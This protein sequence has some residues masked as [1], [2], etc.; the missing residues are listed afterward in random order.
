MLAATVS[1]VLLAATSTTIDVRDSGHIVRVG[2]FKP[3]QYLGEHSFKGGVV[4]T[5]G[6]AIKAYGRAD[7]KD[8]SGCGNIWRKLGVRLVTA[9]FGGGAPC[10][11]STP[12][13]RIEITA[14]KWQ[15]E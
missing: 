3:K 4:P 13:Q 14:S 2:D 11:S 15:T 5:R 10:V 6:N 12:V 8:S 7:K 9:D 1:A